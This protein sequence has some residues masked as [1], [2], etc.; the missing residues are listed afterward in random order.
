LV[1]YSKARAEQMV[2]SFR[3]GVLERGERLAILAAGAL[4]G[5]MI[6]ALWIIA[7]GSTITAIQR[8]AR[9]YREME[10]L[11]ADDRAGLGEHT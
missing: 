11:D 6:P 8:I 4:F 7:I 2:S 5:F 1:S 3:V 9:A 10:R